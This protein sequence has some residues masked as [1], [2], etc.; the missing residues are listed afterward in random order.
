LYLPYSDDLATNKF[1]RRRRKYAGRKTV[2]NKQLIGKVKNLKETK[3]LS[4]TEIT[5][6]TEKSRATI[7]KVLKEDLGFIS[8]GLVK[9]EK[10]YLIRFLSS[11]KISKVGNKKN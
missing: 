5:R 8:N 4:V 10:A 2:S 6:F 1:Y 7:Y 3:N 9:R 11:F